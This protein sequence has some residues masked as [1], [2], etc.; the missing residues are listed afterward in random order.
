MTAARLHLLAQAALCFEQAG[1][2]TEAARCRE[3]AGELVAAGDLF[4]TVGDLTQ[5][6]GCYQRAGHTVQAA[7]CLLALGRPRDAAQLWVRA[8]QPLEAAWVLAV[9]ARDPLGA[10]RLLA[11]MDGDAAPAVAALPGTGRVRRAPAGLGDEL[12]LRL[13]Q[14]MCTALEPRGARASGHQQD[15][16]VATLHEIEERLPA[17]SPAAAQERLVRWAVQA[18]DQVRRP[19]LAAGVFAAAYRCRLRGTAARWREW[20]RA[21]LDGTAGI[22]ERDL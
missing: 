19:D 21:A 22:P 3:K 18:A 14:A 12:R 11:D 17:V 2:L 8:D 5:A 7:A 10:R 6:A 9:D 20:A 15:R 4:R 1:Q 13:T 16:L